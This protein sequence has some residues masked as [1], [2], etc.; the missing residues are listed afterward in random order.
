M[1]I[2]II[3]Y[4]L[5]FANVAEVMMEAVKSKRVVEFRAH[6]RW[7]NVYCRT[8][9]VDPVLERRLLRCGPCLLQLLARQLFMRRL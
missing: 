4:A 7:L 2:A 9:Q 5:V 6:V 1:F 8:C 3:A